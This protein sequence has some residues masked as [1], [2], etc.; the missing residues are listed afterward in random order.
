MN[1]NIIKDDI[2]KPYENKSA[3]HIRCCILAYVCAPLVQLHAQD[4]QSN[5]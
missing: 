1:N 2:I 3:V 5:K 4:K